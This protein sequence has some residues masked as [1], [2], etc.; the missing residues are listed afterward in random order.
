MR[1]DAVECVDLTHACQLDHTNRSLCSDA[2]GCWKQK[3]IE[4]FNASQRNRYDIRQQCH[5]DFP[6]CYNFSD[7]HTYLDSAQ[8]R[9]MLH[10]NPGLGPWLEINGNVFETFVTD[11]D[12]SMSYDSY[13]ADLL[14]AGLRV[15]IYAGAHGERTWMIG[16]VSP[17][18][19][20]MP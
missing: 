2:Q 6:L 3:L 4:P 5:P 14:D 17:L 8:V 10:V 1:T 18:P 9:E 19:I 11:G 12:W 15:L 20:A 16:S 13:V 7:I